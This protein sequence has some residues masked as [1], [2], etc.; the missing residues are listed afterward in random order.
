MQARKTFGVAAL[1][2]VAA[3]MV[4][5]E[6]TE[7]ANETQAGG[8]GQA[9]VTNT[10]AAGV[11]SDVVA[12]P[13]PPKD[14]DVIA[15]VGEAKMTWADLNK[16]VDEMV[17]AYG[18][19]SGQPIPSEMLPQA[20]QAFRRQLVQQ[21][22]I[23][24]VMK[25]TAAA[26]NLAVDDA[27]RAEQTKE[28]EAREGRK[29]DELIKTFP[30]GE[31]KARE[32]LENQWLE[33]KV[34]ETLVFPSVKV[35]DEEVQAEL[36]K[37]AAEKKLVDDEMAG[38]AKQVADGTATF[39]DLV[40][41]NSAVKSPTEL[42]A[43]QLTMGFP[44]EVQEAIA[45][46]KD[47]E[48]TGVL[49]VPGA[50]AI[51]KVVKRTP[52]QP[53]TQ[54]DRDAAKA[55]LETA[56]DRILKGEDFAKVAQEISD[57]PSGQRGGD[58]GEFGKGQMVPEFEQAAF[59]QKVGEVGPVVQTKFGYHIIKVTARDDKVGT[60]KASH[61]LVKAEDKPALISLLPLIKPAPMPR[62]AESIRTTFTEQRKRQAAMDF[63]NAQKKALGVT[64]TLFPELAAE[65]PKADA[66]AAVT[67]A[68]VAAKPAEAKP[69]PAPAD[70][71]ASAAEKPAP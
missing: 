59:S 31:A 20:K 14:T 2:A 61:I 5:C 63:F 15:S 36:D 68:P 18:K 4:G 66:P 55:K 52:A 39:E 40:K 1:A 38:Y 45:S 12:L 64:C 67:P 62:D 48:V 23:E 22:I 60:V 53:L 46:T 58:L 25:Q 6:K 42:P 3:L 33:M 41:A 47:G 32:M 7:P 35:T 28:L 71:P 70:K 30:L 56:R 65:P 10:P 51:F 50:K 11:E 27:F 17:E 37:F 57:C 26:K 24:G 16:Q 49:D 43:D 21:F 8:Q 44:K 13:P 69:T 29:L 9:A 19:M 54:A 34:L